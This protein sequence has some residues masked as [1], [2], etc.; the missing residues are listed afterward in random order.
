MCEVDLRG[1]ASSHSMYVVGGDMLT[2]P[3]ESLLPPLITG[4]S[5]LT[6]IQASILNSSLVFST[7][8]TEYIVCVE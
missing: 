5:Q 7:H 1:A 8:I 4:Q 6:G 3:I 2:V